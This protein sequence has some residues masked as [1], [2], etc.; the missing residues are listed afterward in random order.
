MIATWNS[1]R[2]STSLQACGE[3]DPSLLGGQLCVATLDLLLDAL[4]IV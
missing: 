3:I 1:R 2:S 4:W